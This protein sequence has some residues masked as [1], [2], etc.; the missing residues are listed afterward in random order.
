MK[1]IFDFS[2]ED[3]KD[4]KDES[5]INSQKKEFEQSEYNNTTEQAKNMYDKYKNY[6]QEELLNEF[7]TTS[8]NKLKNGSLTPQKIE[9]TANM[10]S[11]Y[12]NNQQKEFLKG[13]LDRLND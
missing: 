1:N 6:S 8:K 4:E 12:L 2:N 5:Y 3:L 7:I 13:L 9:Q 11:P 10:L